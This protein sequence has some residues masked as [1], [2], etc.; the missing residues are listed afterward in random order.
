MISYTLKFN[1]RS[2]HLRLAV[3]PDCSVTVTAPHC[4]SR[5]LIEN[6]VKEKTDWIQ[7][8]IEYYKTFKPLIK[9]S[10]ANYLNQKEN[11][12][13][14]AHKKVSYFNNFYN[15]KYN[16]ISIKNQKTCW[17]SCSK[18]GN[19]NFNYKIALIPEE[20]A[21]YIVAHEICHLKEFNHSEKFWSLVARTIPDYLE[22]RVALKKV[23][24]A[25]Q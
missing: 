8:R 21:D 10:K 13:A 20:L 15:F 19:L 12:R 9:D 22:R 16:K 14:L 2:R 18:K 4:V 6:F 3:S 24:I 17:G 11:A 23:G 5:D 25:L 1:R 7:G